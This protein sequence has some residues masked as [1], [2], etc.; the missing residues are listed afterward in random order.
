MPSDQPWPQLRLAIACPIANEAE[1]ARSFVS[2]LLQACAGLGAVSLIAVFDR[3]CHDRTPE[4]LAEMS[5]ADPRIHV[6]W[7][8]EGRCPA[9]AYRRAYR[10]ALAS[11]Y[12]WVLEINAGYRHQPGDLLQFFPLMAGGQFDCIFGSRFLPGG[13]MKTQSRQR[14]LLSERGTTLANL[15][16]GTRLTDMT[17]GYEMFR[18]EV[19]AMVMARGIRSR[20]HFLQTEIKALC[21][22]QRVCE[23]PIR[24]ASPGQA[25]GARV[26]SDAA[27]Q[28]LRV[29]VLRFAGAL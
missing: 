14:R 1:T 20:F 27:W 5:Q 28:L 23:V 13:S 3:A 18:R 22:R 4:I 17:S 25:L 29:S 12:E 8:R 11:G 10:E 15:L 7:E 16:L 19:L 2:E 24:Y 21:R 6:V 9:D 26:L